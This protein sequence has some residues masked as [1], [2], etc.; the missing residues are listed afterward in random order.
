VVRPMGRR[1]F[2]QTRGSRAVL[3]RVLRDPG[4]SCVGGE[5]KAMNAEEVVIGCIERKARHGCVLSGWRFVKRQGKSWF[6][7]A[8]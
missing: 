3:A 8:S 1:C 7:T 6:K 5:E 4:S 2:F